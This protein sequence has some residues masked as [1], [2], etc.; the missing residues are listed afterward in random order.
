MMLLKSPV[1]L[2][3]TLLLL[4][5]IKID[6]WEHCGRYVQIALWPEFAVLLLASV[7]S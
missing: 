6:S 2:W 1:S 5:V 7:A 4:D 3:A